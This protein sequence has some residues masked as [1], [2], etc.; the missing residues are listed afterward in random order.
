M[1]DQETLV[2]FLGTLILMGLLCLLFLASQWHIMLLLYRP[3]PKPEPE[4]ED[5]HNDPT[6]EVRAVSCQ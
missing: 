6:I 2:F 4:P 1:P 5:L 3:L